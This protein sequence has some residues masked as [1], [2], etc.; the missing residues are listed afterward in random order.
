MWESPGAFPC[1]V[2]AFSIGAMACYAHF[3]GA[4]LKIIQLDF[5]YTQ[6]TIFRELACNK[7]LLVGF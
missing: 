7:F 3:N 5:V 2:N 4:N 1:A 6:S